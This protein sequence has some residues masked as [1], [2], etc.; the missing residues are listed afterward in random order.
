[1]PFSTAANLSGS[2]L[3]EFALK[4]KSL[5]DPVGE[6]QLYNVHAASLKPTLEKF[7][8]SPGLIF[9]HIC[10]YIYRHGVPT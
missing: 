3:C 7:G 1:M 9:R 5:A 6:V 8:D 4:N 2:W 10:T